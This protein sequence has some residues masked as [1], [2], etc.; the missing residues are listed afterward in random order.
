MGSYR[1]V[2]QIETT[3]RMELQLNATR[4]RTKVTRAAEA[5]EVTLKYLQLPAHRGVGGV[6]PI[7]TVSAANHPK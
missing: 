1:E 6:T 7:Y 4:D 5:T 2:V 3:S